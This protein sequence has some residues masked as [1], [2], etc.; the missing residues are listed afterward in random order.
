[1][2]TPLDDQTRFYLRNWER[3]E[4]W[5]ALRSEAIDSVKTAIIAA[6][7]GLDPTVVTDASMRWEQ[8]IDSTFPTFELSKPNWCLDDRTVAVALQ[9]QQQKQP[10]KVS[11]ASLW[12]WIGIR[13]SGGSAKD[14]AAVR[15]WK[16]LAE[17]AAGLQW[18]ERELGTGWLWWKRLH[19]IGAGDDLDTLTQACRDG[20][21]AGWSRMSGPIDDWFRRE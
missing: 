7:E 8:A 1:M 14:I 11:D 2:S 12:P 19:P 20:L 4:T 13:V 3:I 15:L 21:H 9:W 10:R 18:H 16:Q 17:P 6:V 5:L